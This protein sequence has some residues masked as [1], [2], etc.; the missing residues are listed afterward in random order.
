[1]FG[2]GPPGRDRNTVSGTTIGSR[3]PRYTTDRR[4]TWCAG[5]AYEQLIAIG[6]AKHVSEL[7]PPE[8]SNAVVCRNDGPKDRMQYAMPRTGPTRQRQ[9]PLVAPRT[10][11]QYAEK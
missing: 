8:E 5:D 10:T 3:F 2:R 1:M 4:V 7:I 11:R 6:C 9:K